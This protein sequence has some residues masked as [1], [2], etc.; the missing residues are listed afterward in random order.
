[1]RAINDAPV[2]K[3]AIKGF[4]LR[5]CDRFLLR[6][7]YPICPSVLRVLS[8]AHMMGYEIKPEL[9]AF[10]PFLPQRHPSGD[11]NSIVDAE[12]EGKPKMTLPKEMSSSPSTLPSS[13]QSVI[14][15]VQMQAYPQIQASAVV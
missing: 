2:A 6:Y 12:L 5:V 10:C 4:G 8:L 15:Q 1:M 3:H 7:K 9:Q 14:Q 11:E 13:M